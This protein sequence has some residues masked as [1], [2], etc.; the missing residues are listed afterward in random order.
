MNAAKLPNELNKFSKEDYSDTNQY[1][2]LEPYESQKYS[3]K[4]NTT[5]TGILIEA[6]QVQNSNIV[7][8][9]ELKTGIY[10]MTE[11][12][13]PGTSSNPGDLVFLSSENSYY[14]SINNG[15]NDGND[16]WI[17]LVPK[18]VRPNSDKLITERTLYYYKGN[19]NI[20]TVGNITEGTWNGDT[21]SVS[22]GGTGQTFFSRYHI[23]YG[24]GT[25]AIQSGPL[26]WEDWETATNIG[27]KAVFK[28]GDSSTINPNLEYTSP[29]IPTA[30]ETQSG[31]VTA[32]T[33]HFG[34]N[35][36]F[37]G[38]QLG[39]KTKNSNL[40]KIIFGTQPTPDVS[41]INYYTSDTNEWASINVT[42]P[43][44]TTDSNREYFIPQFS[45][46]QYGFSTTYDE[47]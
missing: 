23:L 6:N 13:T 9:I 30:T 35:K 45:F 44:E 15:L 26:N 11:N 8:S 20:D 42:I 16:K 2:L 36:F 40:N 25:D 18:S 38:G 37:T 4:I 32:V 22:R 12:E 17:K 21:I 28:I 7:Y 47:S 39:I 14:A 41:G 10:K 19:E 43:S 27:P 29:A 5:E 34:G 1:I 46:K 3:I 33:Q 31:I 24:N